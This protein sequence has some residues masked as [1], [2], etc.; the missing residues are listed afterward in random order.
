MVHA[1]LSPLPELLK[2]IH[3][4]SEVNYKTSLNNKSLTV[5]PTDVTDVKEDG[6]TLPFNGLLDTELSLKVN[7]LIEE[8]KVL[9]K[10]HQVLIKLE[11]SQS[12][13]KVKLL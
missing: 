6:P 9:A 4:S 11:E 12:L 1:G 2:D 13:L 7:I 5:L 3:M 8:F 10:S